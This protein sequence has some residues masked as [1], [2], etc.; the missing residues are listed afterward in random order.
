MLNFVHNIQNVQVTYCL[1]FLDIAAN[2]VRGL[3]IEEKLS[4]FSCLIKNSKL[5]GD[6]FF[7][8][9]LHTINLT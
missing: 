8:V 3:I 5:Q 4:L 1:W 9:S 2:V 6:V 7:L